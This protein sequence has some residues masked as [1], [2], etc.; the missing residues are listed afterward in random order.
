MSHHY[1]IL[2]E[3][4]HPCKFYV[5]PKRNFPQGNFFESRFSSIP[6]EI[7]RKEISPK[8]IFVSPKRVSEVCNANFGNS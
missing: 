8:Y 7:S 4:S 1:L 5:G 3:K 2:P 6:E